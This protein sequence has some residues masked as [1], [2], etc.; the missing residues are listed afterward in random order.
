M[1][2]SNCGTVVLIALVTLSY[3]NYTILS[4]LGCRA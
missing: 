3:P 4:E 2:S 1:V